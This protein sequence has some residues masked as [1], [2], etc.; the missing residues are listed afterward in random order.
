MSAPVATRQRSPAHAYDPPAIHT[1]AAFG[2]FLRSEIEFP[3]LTRAADGAVANWTVAVDRAEPG[4]EAFVPIGERR[5]RQ[6]QYRLWRGPEGLRLE[7][8]HAGIFDLVSD[9]SRIVWYHRSDAL[10]EL[11]RSIII[12][13]VIALALELGGFLC[14]HGSAVTI[15]SSAIAFLGPKHFGKST[16][17]TALTTAGAKLLGDDLLVVSPGP[18]AMV[19]PGVASVRLWADMAAA[20]PLDSVCNTLIG[21]VK[22]T[23]TGFA[24]AAL[25]EKPA[26]IDA[27]Y[28]L[29]PLAR[30]ADG[31]A[32]RRTRLSRTEA[33]IA[34][35]HQT[36]LPDSLVGFRAAG[37]QL[38]S[39]AAVAAS[40]P[41]W[42]LHTIRDVARLGT[43][44]RQIIE[45]TCQE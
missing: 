36:K 27:I 20:L 17:A 10:P 42:R 8:S 16:L 33:T 41:V 39:A 37:S 4:W 11:V 28:L 7:Y 40:V 21:G 14:L 15:E 31:P 23:V 5:I 2:G 25:A 34:L 3:E 13:P 24:E 44:V 1:Y 18:P 35:A 30:D 26:I 32:V 45:W 38:A 6:E 9:G 22:T 29:S 12:G 19:C 43:T